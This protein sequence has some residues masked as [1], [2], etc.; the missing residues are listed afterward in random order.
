MELYTISGDL[1]QNKNWRVLR[2]PTKCSKHPPTKYHLFRIPWGYVI[3]THSF[4]TKT[5]SQ[6]KPFL[7]TT[8]GTCLIFFSNYQAVLDNVCI[9]STTELL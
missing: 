4:S 8:L 3:T 7:L 2:N 9:T 5:W 6:I 1:V